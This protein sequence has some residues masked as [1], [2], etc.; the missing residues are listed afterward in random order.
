MRLVLTGSGSFIAGHVKIAAEEAGLDVLALRHDE[1]LAPRLA[2]EDL[3]VNFALH[4]QYRSGPYNS[5]QDYDLR[6]ACAAHAAGARMAMLST[7]RIYP[8]SAR[9]NAVEAGWTS[10]DETAYGRNKAQSEEVVS[11]ETG[12]RALILRLSNV[13]G[14]EYDPA[15][16]RRSFLGLLLGT[17]K[18]EDKIRFDMHPDTRRDFIPVELCA[19]AMVQAFRAGLE[20][21]YNLGAGFPVRCGDL[22]DWIC[23]GFGSGTLIVDPPVVTDEFYLNMDRWNSRLPAPIDSE[24][25][26]TYCI[27]LGQRTKCAKS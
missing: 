22:A 25:L 4:P 3:V 16:A 1:P 27:E 21:V 14:M 13:F 17:L 19:R 5:E 18:R 2:A 12:G 11:A 8:P 15:G 20:G 6:A 9:W 23:E 10:G 26:K 7:R 24:T